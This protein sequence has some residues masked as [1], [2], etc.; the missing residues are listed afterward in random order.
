MPAETQNEEYNK[1]ILKMYD[2]AQKRRRMQIDRIW[3]TMKHVTTLIFV[4][5][6]A[7]AALLGYY[8]Q[9]M[10]YLDGPEGKIPAVVL[11]PLFMLFVGT[12]A[13]FYTRRQ[14]SRFLEYLIWINNIEEKWKLTGFLPK[15]WQDSLEERKKADIS[16]TE[17][18]KN[19]LKLLT[20][21]GSMFHHFAILFILYCLL[22]GSLLFLFLSAWENY[23]IF[24]VLL[25]VYAIVVFPLYW[26]TGYDGEKKPKESPKEK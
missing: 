15:R 26:K 20:L 1:W 9:N 14:Y 23:C 7:I 5:I 24:L 17:F 8:G 4:N 11:F 16:E 6:A 2:H 21:K 12:W 25:G 19:H 13:I 22:A 18:I 10:R 3:E